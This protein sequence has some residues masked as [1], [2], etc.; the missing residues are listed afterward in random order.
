MGRSFDVLFGNCPYCCNPVAVRITSWNWSFIFM[1]SLMSLDDSITPRGWQLRSYK[2]INFI[3]PPWEETYSCSFVK[4][5][6]RKYKE[7]KPFLAHKL[8]MIVISKW[9][10]SCI[11][12]IWLMT[13]FYL[14]NYH[15]VLLH[16]F[17]AGRSKFVHLHL[18]MFCLYI[19]CYITTSRVM[20][21]I[22]PE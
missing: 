16:L 7:V 17:G 19:F 14:S 21:L 6:L 20:Q 9:Y 10:V 2:K 3:F 1:T 13:P 11:P 18:L 4:K 12:D 22:Y 5:V 15:H 8:F